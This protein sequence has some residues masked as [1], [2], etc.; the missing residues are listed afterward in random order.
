[1]QVGC[2]TKNSFVNL[3]NKVFD[4][5]D[6]IMLV[7]SIDN[8][9][10]A[11]ARISND[12]TALVPYTDDVEV[13][14][15][16]IRAIR[17]GYDNAR[18]ATSKAKEA[19]DNAVKSQ[20]YANIAKNAK[21][22]ALDKAREAVDYANASKLSAEF[23]D[24]QRA[25]TKN[26]YNDFLEKKV[27]IVGVIDEYK[28]FVSLSKEQIY[29]IGTVLKQRANEVD[30]AT[31][32]AL[33]SAER[34]L[35]AEK[36]VKL[37]R[38]EIN[39]SENRAKNYRDE[40]NRVATQATQ[41]LKFVSN[42][43]AEVAKANSEVQEAKDEVAEMYGHLKLDGNSAIELKKEMYATRTGTLYEMRGDILRP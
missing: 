14:S 27:Q 34:V 5:K 33:D 43:G 12:I 32:L 26:I 7:V 41:K 36:I 13:V 29:D 17:D 31:R 25:K 28:H 40:S 38:V 37:L 15:K 16:N 35:D 24:V 42:V 3:V 11:V 1:M 4:L 18:I 20:E 22:V 6:E 30:S 19:F 2:D 8:E 23:A 21:T 9:L 10:R 39:E